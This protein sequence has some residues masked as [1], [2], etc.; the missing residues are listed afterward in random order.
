VYVVFHNTKQKK[1]LGERGRNFYNQ[2]PEAKVASRKLEVLGIAAGMLEKPRKLLA[3]M[4]CK[5]FFATLKRNC[6][7][8]RS[9]QET[10]EAKESDIWYIKGK[11]WVQP[12]S[13]SLFEERLDGH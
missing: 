5:S 8:A 4:Q 11:L 12:K 6:L 9:F 10:K 7:H 1:N 3:T 13:P 2:W